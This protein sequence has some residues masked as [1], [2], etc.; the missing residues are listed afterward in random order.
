[1]FKHLTILFLLL[2]CISVVNAANTTCPACPQPTPY[3]VYVTVTVPVPV[4]VTPTPT[5]NP[6]PTIF[7][8]PTPPPPSN[9]TIVTQLSSNTEYIIYAALFLSLIIGIILMR[10]KQKKVIQ[11]PK[12]KQIEI[13]NDKY[14]NLYEEEEVEPEIKPVKKEKPEPIK[15]PKKPKK[16]K[17]LL[18]QDFEF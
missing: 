7:P 14:G 18:D 16:P 17:S 11:I 2:L 8:Y 3:I 13:I 5:I 12:P 6:E 10:R 4:T 1:M 9:P 15:K